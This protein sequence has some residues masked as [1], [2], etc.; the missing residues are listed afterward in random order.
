MKRFRLLDDSVDVAP[1]VAELAAHPEIWSLDTERQASA[2][3]Q[4]ETETVM[5]CG[6]EAGLSFKQA[7]TRHPFRYVGR[8]TTV[9]AALPAATAFVDRLARRV[10]GRTGRAAIVRLPPRGRVYEHTD[11]GLYYQLRDRFHLVL[12]SEAGSPLRAGPQQI[13]MREGELWWFENR[14]PHEAWNESAQQDRIHL[15]VDVLT[16]RAVATLPVRLASSPRRYLGGAVRRLT[17]G[18]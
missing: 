15:I 3:E 2:T 17:R 1:I 10:R 14:I 11:F 13:H 6:H 7:R 12:Q 4:R 18:H 8:P 9:A 5:L 16:P